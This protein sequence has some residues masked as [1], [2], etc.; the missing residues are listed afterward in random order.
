MKDPLDRI[1]SSGFKIG[2]HCPVCHRVID[3]RIKQRLDL[4]EIKSKPLL[5]G[6][7]IS[8]LV[9]VVFSWLPVPEEIA[10]YGV[11]ITIAVLGI[12]WF[13]VLRY[14]K[15]YSGKIENLLKAFDTE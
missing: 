10:L 1:F 3:S 9:I 7:I 4:E 2:Q 14:W 13:F 8:V 5:W 6:A 11:P 12:V 15:A